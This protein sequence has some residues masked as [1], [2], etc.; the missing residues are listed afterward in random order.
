MG[1]ILTMD[2]FEILVNRATFLALLIATSDVLQITR[3][4]SHGD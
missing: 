1:S 2:L 3:A 4:C